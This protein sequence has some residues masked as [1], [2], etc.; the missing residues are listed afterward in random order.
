MVGTML[1]GAIA[2][3]LGAAIGMGIPLWGAYR[4]DKNRRRQEQANN[5]L[6]W[7]EVDNRRGRGRGGRSHL[8]GGSGRPGN[9]EHRDREGRFATTEGRD[10]VDDKAPPPRT[11]G[12]SG[13]FH[14]AMRPNWK[15]DRAS[16]EYVDTRPKPLA[17]PFPQRQPREEVIGE[18]PKPK[19]ISGWDRKGKT[20]LSQLRDDFM[21]DN[22]AAKEGEEDDLADNFLTTNCGGNKACG[23]NTNN[24]QPSDELDM[25]PEKAC[26]ILKDGTVRNKPLTK[27][28][29]GMFGAR[30][31]RRDQH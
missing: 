9:V 7:E 26:K 1:G 12:G 21:D 27:G 10:K 24:T 23:C 15:Y 16:G 31:S 3:P 14:A 8:R 18:Q 29:R 2:G 17:N 19:T 25:P 28:Q 5:S 6:N 13:D 22:D 30:C 20:R 4:L 11:H